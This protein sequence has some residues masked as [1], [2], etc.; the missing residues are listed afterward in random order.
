MLIMSDEVEI[1]ETTVAALLTS[2]PQAVRFF[3][4]WHLACAGCGFA[5]FCTMKS[6]S[7]TY[8]LEEAKFLA[9]AKNLVTPKHLTWSA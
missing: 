2:H 3:L 8:Q 9:E 1:S 5:R 6:V 7:Q 4:D